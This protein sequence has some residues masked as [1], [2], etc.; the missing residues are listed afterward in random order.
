MS[1]YVSSAYELAAISTG[2]QPH[3]QT[4]TNAQSGG[5]LFTLLIHVAR[6]RVHY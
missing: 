1:G 2:G 5:C 4:A 6:A 3:F